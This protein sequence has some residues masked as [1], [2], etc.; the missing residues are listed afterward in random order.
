ME[1]TL[2]KSAASLNTGLIDKYESAL[3]F[4][5]SVMLETQ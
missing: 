3:G 1:A 2:Y 5:L 4:G